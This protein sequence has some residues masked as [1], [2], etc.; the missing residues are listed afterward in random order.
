MT[1][2]NSEPEEN[3]SNLET[4][5]LNGIDSE[6]MKEISIKSAFTN[7]FP[8]IERLEHM[9]HVE[10]V[11]ADYNK[12]QD[13]LEEVFPNSLKTVWEFYQANPVN[14]HLVTP[15]MF[16]ATSR[17]FEELI[18]PYDLYKRLTK[19]IEKL[20]FEGHDIL[21]YQTLVNRSNEV[22]FVVNPRGMN[23]GLSVESE[24]IKSGLK[25]YQ[26]SWD[27]EVLDDIRSDQTTIWD[28]RKD[29]IPRLEYL[30]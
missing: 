29:A 1:G 4:D 28:L 27:S 3:R 8:T 5:V 25:N 10:R 21:K 15:G 17:T 11:C 16:G 14:Y 24:T 30:G 2:P 26:F 13:V 18:G 9:G 20:D 23:L 22:G 7:L 6:Q 19:E 12:L